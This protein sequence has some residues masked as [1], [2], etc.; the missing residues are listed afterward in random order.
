[1]GRPCAAAVCSL[2]SAVCCLVSGPVASS[3]N[4]CQSVA[5]KQ[6]KQ[7]SKG[8]PGD[9]RFQE[10]IAASLSPFRPAA[11]LGHRAHPIS[12]SSPS[13]LP[14]TLHPPSRPYIH[15]V[16]PRYVAPSLSVLPS[17]P[18]VSHAHYAPDVSAG[19]VV[20]CPVSSTTSAVAA[21]SQPPSFP[22]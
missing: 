5:S 8:G 6:A 4:N 15:F 21:I 10:A 14:S 11:P 18:S 7:A 1:M 22:T 17:T 13:S 12:P 20:P 19:R 16:H 9:S 2:Q 3:F